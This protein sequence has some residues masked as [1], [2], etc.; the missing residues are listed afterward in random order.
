MKEQGKLV[1]YN[2]IEQD[3]TMELKEIED[4]GK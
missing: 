1:I 2:Y 4:S 3:F